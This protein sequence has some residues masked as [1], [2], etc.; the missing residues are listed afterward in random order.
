MKIKTCEI[1]SFGKLCGKHIGFDDGITVVRGRNESG[2]STLSSFVKYVLYGFEGRGSD[3]TKNEKLRYTPW[4]ENA[5]S[6]SL[7][8]ETAGGD[9][10]RVERNSS[11][12][13]SAGRVIS[14]TGSE[15]FAGMEPGEAL[16][17][18][19][20]V[21][22]EKSAF[23]SQP[24]RSVGNARDTGAGLERALLGEDTAGADRAMKELKAAR[25]ELYNSMRRTGI[26]FELERKLDELSASIEEAKK[27]EEDRAAVEK[28]IADKEKNLSDNRIAFER[29]L[30]EMTNIEAYAAEKKLGEIRSAENE[31]RVGKAFL[32]RSTEMCTF[33]G[34]FVSPEFLA[35]LRRAFSDYLISSEGFDAEK[36]LC[37]CAKENYESAGDGE[38]GDI[39]ARLEND[40]DFS[41]EELTARLSELISKRKKLTAWAIVLTALIVTSPFSIILWVKRSKVKKEIRELLDLYSIEKESDCEAFTGGYVK[42]RRTRKARGEEL[43]KAQKAFGEKETEFTLCTDALRE[44]C[45]KL[46]YG[47]RL[48]GKD[49]VRHLRDE[50]TEMLEERVNRY[51]KDRAEYDKAQKILAGL[52][53]GVDTEK[54]ALAA[55]KKQPTEPERDAETVEREIRFFQSANSALEKRIGDLRTD[56]ARLSA[57]VCN[58]A[59]CENKRAG[60][61]EKLSKAVTGRDALELAMTLLEKSRENIR[62]GILPRISARASELF[63]TF[64]EG[65]YKSLLFDENEGI[66]VIEAEK[67]ESVSL[68]YLSAGAVDAAYIA[69]R[70][71]LSEQL[72]REKPTFIFDDS[73]VQMDDERL[74]GVL[75]VLR[76][77]AEEYQIVILTCGTREETYLGEAAK[78]VVLE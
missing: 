27:N 52:L 59:D 26:I 34:F 7:V 9:T 13:G 23:V 21:T 64:T 28:S 57:G 35:K 39:Y 33:K 50:L 71:A 68:G 10:Y 41:P 1:G 25:N 77:M 53:S 45:E 65:K 38:Y 30:A 46:G 63:A 18:V 15:Q 31:A 54:L 67:D 12:K 3:E 37:E 69:L 73:F 55:S 6:G 61:R 40:A 43:K 5:V 8:V 14:A 78:L 70:I 47:D 17:G 16:L 24:D 20:G 32:E 48:G 66:R 51:E 75:D 29:L 42:Y 22:F 19:D 44:M 60:I 4:G 36:K 76:R 11:R 72:C 49:E 74:H 62:S 56:A 2:K 58:A